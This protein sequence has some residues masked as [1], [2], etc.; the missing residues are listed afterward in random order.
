MVTAGVAAALSR[1]R[2]ARSWPGRY[3]NLGAVH[4]GRGAVPG[5]LAGRKPGAAAARSGADA[6]KNSRWPRFHR[7]S[8]RYS[9][10]MVGL[11]QRRT[12]T[13]SGQWTRLE[14][15]R[16]PAMRWILGRI[17]AVDR[18]MRCDRP[19]RCLAGAI[20]A[21]TAPSVSAV[22]WLAERSLTFQEHLE[23]GTR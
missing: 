9:V 21:L 12:R 6:G 2:D 5:D 11:R 18:T 23:S 15:L 1:A 10:L 19:A 8:L 16:D 7:I 20:Q 3:T 17:M 13:G 4:T 22:E 14:E